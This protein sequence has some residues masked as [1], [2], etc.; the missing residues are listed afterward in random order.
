MTGKELKEWVATVHDDATIS[1]NGGYRWDEQFSI[2]A[3]LV[4]ILDLEAR[5]REKKMRVENVDL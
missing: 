2:K 4:L 5:E 3:S 1:I